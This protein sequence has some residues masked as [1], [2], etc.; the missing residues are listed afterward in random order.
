MTIQ[1]PS[2]VGDPVSFS[3]V[4]IFEEWLPKILNTQK[5]IA[6][7]IGAIC[8]F[9]ISGENGGTWTVDLPNQKVNSG[10]SEH[11]DMR[12]E[13]S[14]EDFG[15]MLAGKLDAEAALRDKRLSLFGRPQLLVSLAALMR[16]SENN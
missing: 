3:P 6:T 10:D 1:H 8:V 7:S 4:Q 2:T 11:P 14:A 16:P 5:E 13:M 9:K 15:S 12:L